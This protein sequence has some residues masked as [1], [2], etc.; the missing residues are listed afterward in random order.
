MHQMKVVWRSV[1]GAVHVHGREHNAIVEC[2]VAQTE[3]REHRWRRARV[4]S[5]RGGG[6]RTTREPAL[7]ASNVRRV[8]QPQVFVAHALAA[9][10]QAVRELLRR[11]PDVALDVLEPLHGI[12]RGVLEAQRLRD[13]LAFIAR[14]CGAHVVRAGEGACK[15]NRVFHGQLCS[16]TNGEVRRVCGVAHEHH[17]VVEPMGVAHANKSHPR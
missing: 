14:E 3:R 17:V 9:R 13:A 16:R 7:N 1:C 2:H 8:T 12:A 6:R 10:E 11:Q 15:C 5:G 4:R